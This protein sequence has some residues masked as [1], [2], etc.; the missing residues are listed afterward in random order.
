MAGNIS[1]FISNAIVMVLLFY[2]MAQF[3]PLRVRW[4]KLALFL[5][6]LPV[7][8]V[9][10][11]YAISS[12]NEFLFNFQSYVVVPVIIIVLVIW[13]YGG[14]LWKRILFLV[15]LVT[16]IGVS[17]RI[18]ILIVQP[19]PDIALEFYVLDHADPIFIT[20]AIVVT[21]VMLMVMGL[22][23]WAARVIKLRKFNLAFLVFPIFPL[24]QIILLSGIIR[25][26]PQ[27]NNALIIGVIIC[28][29]ANLAI[30]I[31]MLEQ[32]KK[33]TLQE[34]LRTTRHT[35][36]LQQ[37]HYKELESRR[38]ALSKIR[39]DFN[40]QLAAISQLINTGQQ[41]S[42][43]DL[44]TTLS[45]EIIN[46]K[47]NPYCDIPVINAILLDKA[48]TC[49]D[50]GI[51][52]A[53]DLNLPPAMAIQQ[54]HLCSIF[55]NLMDNAIA[56]CKQVGGAADIKLSSMVDGDYLFIR[57]SNPSPP[58]PKKPAPGRGQGSRILQDIAVQYEGG[59]RGVYED[60]M[61]IAVVSVLAG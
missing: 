28:F 31:V 12:G 46:T 29:I 19:N 40:N 22:S 41:D 37:S 58:Q 18:A 55:G 33:Q 51:N 53:V 13:A 39:H 25:A 21:L 24:G 43:R 15:Y 7:Q 5:L 36:E 11:A 2:T 38:E 20:L 35:M 56:A 52:L 48:Q 23:I 57:I 50:L 34:E 59:Y 1:N 42:A 17:E 16:T 60:G 32:D 45:Y 49:E 4:W 10:R 6:Y 9:W 14:P 30:L 44:I 8:F 61:Y 27:F 54:M 47:E 26:Q 3:V